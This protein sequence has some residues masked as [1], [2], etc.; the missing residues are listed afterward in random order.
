MADA[1]LAYL[2][3][4]MDGPVAAL[5]VLRSHYRMG[6]GR[7]LLGGAAIHWAKT[8]GC[9][10][11]PGVLAENQ[12]V[13]HFYEAMGAGLVSTGTYEWDGQQLPDAIYVFENLDRLAA[14]A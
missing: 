3:D 10:L 8:G 6:I 2:F 9:S 7:R 1:P 14:F 12:R 5:Y 11:A 13:R 4:R